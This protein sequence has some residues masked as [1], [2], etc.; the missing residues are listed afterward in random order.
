MKA[1]SSQLLSIE[2]LVNSVL[3][4]LG[5][6]MHLK[7]KFLKWGVAFFKLW[8]MD[9]AREYKKTTLDMT[10]WKSIILPNDTVDWI[11]IGKGNGEAIDT[12]TINRALSLRDCA[13]DEDVPTESDYSANSGVILFDGQPATSYSSEFGTGKLNLMTKDNGLGYFKPNHIQ[14]S[15]EIQLS[16]QVPAGTRIKLIYLATLFNPDVDLCVH[17][18]AQPMIEA[19]IHWRNLQMKRRSG[20]RN[21]SPQDIRDAKDEYDGELCQLVER[22]WDM[23]VESIVEAAREGFNMA[24]KN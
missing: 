12:F 21:I 18:Y 13:C 8:R 2:E 16:A 3:L 4:D 15:N 17:P 22:R 20:N 23:S 24:P 7:E 11:I 5:E 6:G 1:N 9:M 14:G 19:G 10:P